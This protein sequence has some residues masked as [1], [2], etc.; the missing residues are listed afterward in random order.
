MDSIVLF[1]GM[2]LEKICAHVNWTG[3]SLLYCF[4]ICNIT[5]TNAFMLGDKIAQSPLFILHFALCINSGVNYLVYGIFNSQYQKI[6][7]ELLCC[8]RKNDKF[9]SRLELGEILNTIQKIKFRLSFWNNFFLINRP[10][11]FCK[12]CFWPNLYIGGNIKYF[13]EINDPSFDDPDTI[14]KD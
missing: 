13:I 5:E 14:P 1:L 10:V 4:F 6:F 2:G 3:T 11:L 9:H 12:G 7:L 8:K